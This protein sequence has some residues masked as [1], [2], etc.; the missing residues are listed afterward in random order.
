MGNK[1]ILTDGPKNEN[2]AN[3]R[4]F[5][6]LIANSLQSNVSITYISKKFKST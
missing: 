4:F 1:N 5:F 2:F 3:S 6:R